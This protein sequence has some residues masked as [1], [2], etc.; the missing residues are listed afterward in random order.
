MYGWLAARGEL[1]F[2]EVRDEDATSGWHAVGDVTLCPSDLPIVIGEKD[3]RARHVG[4][5]VI[6]A[7]CERARELGWSEVR[8]DEIYDWNVASQR[9]FS[10]VGFEPYERTDR[11]ARWRRGLQSTT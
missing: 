6:G 3:L 7:L 10:A 9:C 8:V 4:R 11:G 2:I 1:W 5:R